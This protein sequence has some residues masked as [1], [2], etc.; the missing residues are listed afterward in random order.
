MDK[1]YDVPLPT[2]SKLGESP[3][4]NDQS[5]TVTFLDDV[6][7]ETSLFHLRLHHADVGTR[8]R[9]WER[10]TTSATMATMTRTISA[11]SAPSVRRARTT[12]TTTR[13]TCGA[14][15]R[16]VVDAAADDAPTETTAAPTGAVDLG[17]LSD[18]RFSCLRAALDAAEL[19]SAIAGA[20]A[21]NALTVFAPTNAAFARASA[22]R[23]LAFE[24]LAS[25][26][27]LG[28][29]LKHHVVSG[30]VKSTD[31][32]AE[33]RVKTLG[34]RELNVKV[35][36]GSASVDGVAVSEADI[37]VGSGVV[38]HVVDEVVFPAFSINAKIQTPQEILAFEGWAPEVVNGRVAMIGFVLAVLGEISTGEPFATQVGNNFGEVV[39]TSFVWSL[40]SLFPAFSSNEGYEANP[41]KMAGS[42]EWE[43][44]FR[45]C[46]PWL[47]VKDRLSPEVEQ[48]NGRA[49]MVGLTSMLLLET[50]LGHALF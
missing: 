4:P 49:A 43:F 42:K 24:E 11:I 7:P 8:G 45:G 30:A 6:A 19:T 23:G 26:E 2:S 5:R 38:V 35:A 25:R 36:G 37:Q 50:L 48:L 3:T 39:H 22:E 32:P 27:N 18:E 14:K 9:D 44:V 15:T 29:I 47:A 34:G 46:P 17:A 1:Q 12:T 41:F 20:T 21:E 40:A 31:L 13:R 28:D 16:A 10:T 33:G